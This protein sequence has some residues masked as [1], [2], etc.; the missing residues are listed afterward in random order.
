MHPLTLLRSL[1]MPWKNHFDR[2]LIARLQLPLLSYQERIF[3][4]RIEEPRKCIVVIHIFY[5]FLLLTRIMYQLSVFFVLQ[6]TAP[7]K[8]LMKNS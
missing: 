6:L 2:Y 4:S 7:Q 1:A 5:F 8:V 3:P